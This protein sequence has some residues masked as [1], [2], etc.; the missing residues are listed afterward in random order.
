MTVIHKRQG[1]FTIVIIIK[2][3][4]DFSSLNKTQNQIHNF[5]RVSYLGLRFS[6]QEKI[7][8]TVVLMSNN[9]SVV[10][11]NYYLYHIWSDILSK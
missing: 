2:S 8:T 5:E 9:F 11:Q 1:H 7:K 4:H 6:A 10:I 3:R